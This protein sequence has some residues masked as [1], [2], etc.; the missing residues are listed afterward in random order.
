MTH[1]IKRPSIDLRKGRTGDL[2][3]STFSDQE[4]A[5]EFL[6]RF[7]PDPDREGLTETPER[8]VAAWRYWTSGY[9]QHPEDVIKCFG[10]GT[11]KLDEM[12]FQG[13]IATFSLCEHHGAP[14]FGVTHA[15]YIPN[16]RIIGLSK[17]ARVVEI[18]ARR[19]TVQE[20]I[21]SKVADCLM[22]H[23][24]PLGVGVVCQMRHLCMESRGVEKI[25]TITTTS[26]LRGAIKDEDS[27]RSEFMSFVRANQ[28]KG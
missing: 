4:L 17:F 6:R 19:L 24:K 15:A 11:E 8:M 9:D 10:E 23:L 22:E 20:Q 14:F 28:W 16:G 1:Q 7:D 26:A 25:G 12:I 3:L 13:N 5:Q 21:T 27:A 18:F 2:L